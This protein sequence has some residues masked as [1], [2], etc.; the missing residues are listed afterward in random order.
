MKAGKIEGPL[1][2]A[3]RLLARRDHTETELRLKLQRKNFSHPEVDAAMERLR[4]KGYLNDE[5]LKQDMI[6]KMLAE[7]RHGVRGIVGKLR[8]MG[9]QVSGEEVRECCSEEEEW[10]IACQLLKNHFRSLDAE[11]FPRL[12]RYL[13]NRGFSSA[14]MS[15]L[16]EECRKHQ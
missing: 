5:K 3:V 14:I 10:E 8:Q 9:L 1:E 4:E 16:A 12:A 7:K 2:T 13:A 11:N 6:E 15:R